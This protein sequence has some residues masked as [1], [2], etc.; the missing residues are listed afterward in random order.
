MRN[1]RFPLPDKVRQPVK[2]AFVIA[3]T[4]KPNNNHGSSAVTASAISLSPAMEITNGSPTRN[5]RPRCPC[6][7]IGGPG[8]A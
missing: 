8:G 1:A 2:A 3:S 6:V 5:Q 4:F 7:T